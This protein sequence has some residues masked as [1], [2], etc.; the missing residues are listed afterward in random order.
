MS[1]RT[2]KPTGP[3]AWSYD[4]LKNHLQL[5]LVECLFEGTMG[6]FISTAIDWSIRWSVAEAERREAEK[7][8]AL[9]KEK[10]ARKPRANKKL[11]GNMSKKF[12]L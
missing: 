6:Y 4:E 10:A 1:K 8:A 11:I 7:V 3:E 12:G 2:P 5:R 9:A